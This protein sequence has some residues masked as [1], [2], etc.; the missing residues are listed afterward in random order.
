MFLLSLVFCLDTGR[1]SERTLT[2]RIQG[3]RT[4]VELPKETCARYWNW[5][6][7]QTRR[8]DRASD[9]LL[10]AESVTACRP[11]S[12]GTAGGVPG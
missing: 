2:A 9:Y 10:I 4:R 6:D 12:L 1:A 5:H 3:I 11:D 7:P 8:P